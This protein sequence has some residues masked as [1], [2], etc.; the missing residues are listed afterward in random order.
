MGGGGNII[1]EQKRRGGRTSD[2]DGHSM[3]LGIR[4]GIFFFGKR[5]SQSERRVRFYR[6]GGVWGGLRR[7]KRTVTSMSPVGE[8]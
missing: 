6:M 3:M 4:P 2:L 7:E 8:V 1:D 5:W